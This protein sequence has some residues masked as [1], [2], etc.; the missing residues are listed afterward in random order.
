[1]QCLQSRV[2]CNWQ[3]DQFEELIYTINHCL[4]ETLLACYLQSWTLVEAVKWLW[5]RWSIMRLAL[6]P[7]HPQPG[8][9]RS[10]CCLKGLWNVEQIP[11]ALSAWARSPLA[12][13]K[14]CGPA[15]E[16]TEFH[17]EARQKNILFES[18]RLSQ[19]RFDSCSPF[20]FVK[21]CV[22]CNLDCVLCT[23]SVQVFAAAVYIQILNWNYI[24][25]IFGLID[26]KHYWQQNLPRFVLQ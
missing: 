2:D 16:F 13:L 20:L 8:I 25:L 14:S 7:P 17:M 12:R 24:K 21:M 4:H 23:S 6:Q 5:K 26:T 18:N 22:C 9:L 3:T 10:V 19:T 15:R 11:W 1:M